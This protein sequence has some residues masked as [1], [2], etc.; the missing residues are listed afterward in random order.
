VEKFKERNLQTM[1][2]NPSPKGSSKG[3]SMVFDILTGKSLEA[4]KDGIF[5]IKCVVDQ[6][7]FKL[8]TKGKLF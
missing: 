3:K 5:R 1:K 4:K 6:I 2:I 7:C 8:Q